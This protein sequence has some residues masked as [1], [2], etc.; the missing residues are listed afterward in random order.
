MKNYFLFILFLGIGS[1][2]ES[3]QVTVDQSGTKIIT[4]ICDRQILISEPDLKE[5]YEPQYSGY[6]V[7]QSVLEEVDSLSQNVSFIVFLG[8]WCS[9]S[10]REVPRFFKI[11]DEAKIPSTKIMLY[12]VDRTKRSSDGMTDKYHILNVPTIII[13]NGEEE[14]GW[15]VE[16]PQETLEKDLENVLMKQEHLKN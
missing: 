7:D 10:Q 8:T 2:S 15:I 16:F 13:M 3:Y 4:G 6:Q 12:G 1:C 11:A 9:D 5:W 14:L